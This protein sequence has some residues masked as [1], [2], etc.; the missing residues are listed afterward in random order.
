MYLYCCVME[1]GRGVDGG[2]DC[3]LRSCFSDGSMEVALL[4][5]C[6][7]L[8]CATEAAEPFYPVILLHC[9][10][11]CWFSGGRFAIT[12]DDGWHAVTMLLRGT[13]GTLVTTQAVGCAEMGLGSI[14]FVM[15][16]GD[17]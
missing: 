14:N 6:H 1:C 13:G 9:C 4:W 11:L 2:L 3:E 5:L 7:W 16:W 15:G 10:C 17:R 8:N 12:V